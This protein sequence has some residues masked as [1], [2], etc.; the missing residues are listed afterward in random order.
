LAEVKAPSKQQYVS[1]YLMAS[2]YAALGQKDVAF[3]WL[4]R[5]YKDHSYYVVWLNV[6]RVF[7]GIRPDPRF[8]DLLNRIGIAP[9]GG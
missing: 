5:V 3:E 4:E 1:P 9:Q 8:Q 6:D 7:D 2:I